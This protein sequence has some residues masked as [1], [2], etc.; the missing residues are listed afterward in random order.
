MQMDRAGALLEFGLGIGER[1]LH[2]QRIAGEAGR[3][4]EPIDIEPALP[5]DRDEDPGLARMEIEM[6]RP[7]AEPRSRLDRREIGEDAVLEAK[8]L[9]RARIL[10]LSARGIVAAGYQE[11]DVVGWG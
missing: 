11:N 1:R 6:A 2:E 10:G 7:E 9:D 5:L 3:G 8:G 4:I